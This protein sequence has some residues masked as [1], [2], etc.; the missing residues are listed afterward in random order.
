MAAFSLVDI[1]LKAG[2]DPGGAL[3]AAGTG[4]F[5]A[6][7]GGD[8]D[9][10]G[11]KSASAAGAKNIASILPKHLPSISGLLSTN[12]TLSIANCPLRQGVVYG[13]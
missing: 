3:L 11:S 4:A 7:I 8:K 1:I 5:G 13:L 10:G 6:L 2:S 9:T 12:L